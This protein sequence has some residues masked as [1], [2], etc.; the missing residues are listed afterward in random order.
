MDDLNRRFQMKKIA[1]L[2]AALATVLVA[3][4]TASAKE[5]NAWT[6]D[7]GSETTVPV[8][9]ALDLKNTQ[10]GRCLI[11]REGWTNLGQTD[12]NLA[13]CGGKRVKFLRK[14]RSNTGPLLCGETFALQVG[15]ECFRK[16]VNPQ[17]AGINVCS[18]KCGK[19]MHYQWQFRGCEAGRPVNPK[20]PVAL[21]NLER[22]DSLVFGVR[23]GKVADTC[24]ADKELNGVCTTLR[25]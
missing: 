3:M 16:C 18:E 21:W 11:F 22:Q 20:T 25:D 24:W 1:M 23:P 4:Q 2:G 12:W 13:S 6:M 14:D 7:V 10:S 15:N 8:G 5:V 19:D 17:P 9:K